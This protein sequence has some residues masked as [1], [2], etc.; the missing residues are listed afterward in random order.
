MAS[1][2]ADAKSEYHEWI[3]ILHKVSAIAA[4]RIA[5]QPQVDDGSLGV[6]SALLAIDSQFE[7]YR[8]QKLSRGKKVDW[9]GLLAHHISAAA[10]D[11]PERL[12]AQIHNAAISSLWGVLKVATLYAT[13]LVPVLRR[14]T[15]EGCK[16]F[17]EARIGFYLEGIDTHGE[18]GTLSFSKGTTTPEKMFTSAT[19][20]T[21]D[22]DRSLGTRGSKVQTATLRA[23]REGLGCFVDTMTSEFIGG[24]ITELLVW[25]YR[26]GGPRTSFLPL[27]VPTSVAG[28]L[29]L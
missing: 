18:F 8:Y 10:A 12:P 7:A 26:E 14:P 24:A 5:A 4:G 25:N 1:K 11:V 2:T 17:I 19:L 27:P 22:C 20:A 21:I 13:D 6:T 23:L 16:E 15:I 3:D 9:Q 29:V 28:G